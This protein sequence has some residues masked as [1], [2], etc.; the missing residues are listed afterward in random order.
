MQVLDA[1]AARPSTSSQIV[2]VV[3]DVTHGR[4]GLL[5]PLL[6]SL[7]RRGLVRAEWVDAGAGRRRLHGLP[8]ADFTP[9]EPPLFAPATPA[10]ERLLEFSGRATERLAFAPRLREE[11]RAEILHHLQDSV[12]ASLGAGTSSADAEDAAVRAFGDP[13]KSSVD[14]ARTAQGRRTVLFP[15][16]VREHVVGGVIYDLRVLVL[17]LAAIAFVR[18]QVVT[19]YHIP[20]KSMEPTLHGDPRHGDRILV[21]KLAGAPERFDIAVF[22]GWAEDRKNYVKRCVARP[23]EKLDLHE[24]DVWIDGEL[25]RKEGDAYEALLVEVYDR[26]RETR[27]TESRVAADSGAAFETDFRARVAELWRFDGVGACEMQADEAA[28]FAGFRLRAPDEPAPLAAPAQLVWHEF[29]EDTYVDPESGDMRIGTRSVCDQRVTAS[30]KPVPHTGA[31]VEMALTRGEDHEYV[32]TL[33]G[34]GRGV[35]LYADKVEVARAPDVVLR[36][37]VP[38]KVSF[39]QVDYVLRLCVDGRLVLRHDLPAPDDP[40]TE[41]Q[42]GTPSIR[43]PRGAAWIDPLRLER[44]VYWVPYPTSDV[45]RLGPDEFFMLGDNSSN[46]HDSRALGPVHRRRLVGAPLLVVWPPDRIRVPK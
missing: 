33:C 40:R 17:I 28:P 45:D 22:E 14:L 29:V 43:V 16:D 39:S 30:V 27:R 3:A 9:P 23:G 20:T 19:A 2:A 11:F 34:D 4:E 13:W 41:G 26:E 12:A 6:L 24:G 7:R 37:G 44:D 35:A 46:S 1:I 8:D 18:L 42:P 36:E 5:F 38:T 32:A 21:N 15:A 25:V 31:R 10:S